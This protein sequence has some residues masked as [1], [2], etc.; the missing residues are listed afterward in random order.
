MRI[1]LPVKVFL[2]DGKRQA[3]LFDSDTY[4]IALDTIQTLKKNNVYENA[5][6]VIVQ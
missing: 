5:R 2:F 4:S 6:F 3:F 1:Q